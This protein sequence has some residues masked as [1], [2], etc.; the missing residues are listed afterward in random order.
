ML[1]KHKAAVYVLSNKGLLVFAHSAHPEVGFQGP[2]GT[3]RAGESPVDAAV[4]ELEEETGLLAHASDL[5]LLGIFEHDMRPFRAERQLRHAFLLVQSDDAQDEWAH[6]ERHSDSPNEQAIEFQFHWEPL[7]R[8]L[9]TL[10]A[11]GQGAPIR[12]LCTQD[13]ET[14]PRRLEYQFLHAAVRRAAM[15]RRQWL[16]KLLLDFK[17]DAIDRLDAVASDPVVGSLLEHVAYMAKAASDDGADPTTVFELLEAVL[18]VPCG[19]SLLVLPKHLCSEVADHDHE[20]PLI[21]A[22]SRAVEAAQNAPADEWLA[23]LS[24]LDHVGS[25]ATLEGCL[26]IVVD[27]GIKEPPNPTRSFTHSG[28]LGTAHGE[29]VAGEVQLAETMLREAT[30]TWLNHA[31]AALQPAGFSDGQYWSPWRH[32]LLPAQDILQA[33]FVSSLLCQFFDHCRCS[34]VSLDKAY[35]ESRLQAESQVLRDNLAPLTQALEQI[36]NVALRAVL[37]EDINRALNLHKRPGIPS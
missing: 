35:A 16:G 10:L 32:R 23:A 9:P 20:T 24:L 18:R 5:E 3:V 30:R 36:D 31:F 11:V 22:T 19:T 21:L 27:F 1:E 37:S 4:R 7:H 17:P 14:G 6:W 34:E 25:T 2:A 28:V 33:A 26:G 15:E 29:R 13:P 12:P 8:F